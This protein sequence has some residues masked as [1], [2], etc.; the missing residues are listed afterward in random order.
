MAKEVFP[1]F[2]GDE[3]SWYILQVIAGKSNFI[4]GFIFFIFHLKK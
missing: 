1:E 4:F 2:L 3:N